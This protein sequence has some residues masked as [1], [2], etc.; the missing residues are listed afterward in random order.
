M[1]G[2]A[3]RYDGTSSAIVMWL[4]NELYKAI[5]LHL[6]GDEARKLLLRQYIKIGSQDAA[7]ELLEL[8]P[9]KGD[10][11]TLHLADG[12]NT[13]LSTVVSAPEMPRIFPACSLPEK[14][15]QQS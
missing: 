11:M 9:L 5:T 10:A 1:F 13:I 6:L 14:K 4:V 3:C 8:D 7:R 2:E 12:S 15:I